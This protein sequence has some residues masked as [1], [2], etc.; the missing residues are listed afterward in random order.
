MRHADGPF[1]QGTRK[2][3]AS[4]AVSAPGPCHDR[5]G[6]TPQCIFKL[7]FGAEFSDSLGGCSR[8][9]SAVPRVLD[10]AGDPL[11]AS[12]SFPLRDGQAA[13]MARIVYPSNDRASVVI[14]VML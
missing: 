14:F 4:A 7:L 5:P 2:G 13:K 8:D 11:C 9:L 3:I 10:S 6:G 12:T 1:I